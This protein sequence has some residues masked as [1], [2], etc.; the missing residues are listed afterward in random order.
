MTPNL[1]F[2]TKVFNALVGIIPSL[3]FLRSKAWLPNN[4][5]VHPIYISK[6]LAKV[7][8]NLQ[9]YEN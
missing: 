2:T 4:I 9:A 7:N 1:N 6:N 5:V 3:L 8:T